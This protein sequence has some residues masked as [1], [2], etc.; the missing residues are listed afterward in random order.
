[1]R[2]LDGAVDKNIMK[3]SAKSQGNELSDLAKIKLHQHPHPPPT[4][5]YFISVSGCVSP[6][7][8][9]ALFPYEMS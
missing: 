2:E 6:S 9:F 5:L 3:K 1:M 7:D 8:S 4:I